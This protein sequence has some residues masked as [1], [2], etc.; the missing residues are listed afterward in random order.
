LPTRPKISFVRV[1]REAFEALID[2]QR[3]RKE[4]SK[5]VETKRRNR[6][7]DRDCSS[8]KKCKTYYGASEG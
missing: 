2:K 1:I 6:K 5:M 3:M 4:L 8:H 7:P